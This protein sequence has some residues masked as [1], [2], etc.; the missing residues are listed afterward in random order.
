[1][2]ADVTLRSPLT[3]NRA[4]RGRAIYED[5]FTFL[6]ARIDNLKKYPE[7]AKSSRRHHFFLSLAAV[8][9]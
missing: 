6:Q 8:L 1:M 2:I 7:L 3:G 9:Q 5:G 4:D